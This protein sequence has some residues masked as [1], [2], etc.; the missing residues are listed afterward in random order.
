[1]S[2]IF[3]PRGY[4]KK[5]LL[6]NMNFILQRPKLQKFFLKLLSFFPKVKNRLYIVF[7]NN[8]SNFHM[9]NG[10]DFFITGDYNS[11]SPLEKNIY[12]IF[13]N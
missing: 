4:V 8:K 9:K 5:F 1:M 13:R 10:P 2:N 11:L 12:N 7:L 6:L 3:N